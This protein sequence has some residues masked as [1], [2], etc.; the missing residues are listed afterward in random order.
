MNQTFATVLICYASIGI[1]YWAFRVAP[2]LRKSGIHL[3]EW[4]GSFFMTLAGWPA[5]LF[6]Q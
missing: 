6:M 4:I 5:L 2:V 1:A 3:I